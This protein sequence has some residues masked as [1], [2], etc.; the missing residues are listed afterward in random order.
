MTVSGCSLAC[1]PASSCVSRAWGAEGK[2]YTATGRAR[3]VTVGSTMDAWFWTNRSSRARMT[4]GVLSW[5]SFADLA[6]AAVPCRISCTL[7]T[8]S[9]TAAIRVGW[10]LLRASK[11]AAIKSP[12][13]VNEAFSLGTDIT[14]W[15]AL[16]SCCSRMVLP[17]MVTESTGWI[18]RLVTT[19]TPEPCLRCRLCAALLP[20][21][22]ELDASVVCSN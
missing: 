7:A 17:R 21:L 13:P 10:S 6:L 1:L 22:T 20:R 15:E 9:S 19:C 11:S 3:Y 8:V 5:D 16:P 2:D 14:N 4:P 18:S 12:V